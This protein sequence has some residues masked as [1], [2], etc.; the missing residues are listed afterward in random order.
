MEDCIWMGIAYNGVYVW[1]RQRIG[2]D[3]ACSVGINLAFGLYNCR[4]F[5]FY[6]PNSFFLT[7]NKQRESRAYIDFEP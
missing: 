7:L 2:V 5:V 1:G 6:F 4:P 3:E